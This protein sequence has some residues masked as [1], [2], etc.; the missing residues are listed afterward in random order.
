[1]KGILTE[2]KGANRK[3]KKKVKCIETLF[4]DDIILYKENPKYSVKKTVR[5]NQ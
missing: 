4:S 5:S 2:K 1:M 3:K